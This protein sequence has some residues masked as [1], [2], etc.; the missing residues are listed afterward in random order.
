M[1]RSGSPKTPGREC[2]DVVDV[3]ELQWL[4]IGDVG[5]PQRHHQGPGDR[6]FQVLHEHDRPQDRRGKAEGADV[7]LDVPLALEVGDAGVAASTQAPP[8][9]A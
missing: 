4:G 7:L 8:A 1:Y 3:D 6:P 9:K 5:L 2:A